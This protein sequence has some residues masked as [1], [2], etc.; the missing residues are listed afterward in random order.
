M[1]YIYS[2]L[3]YMA[4]PFILLKL[5]W[6]GR[7]Q[8]AYRR[9]I[10]E[11]LG[12]PPFQ[13]ERAIWLHAVSVGE[14]AAAIP[15]IK[16]LQARYPHCPVLV[17]TMTPTG[18]DCV[19]KTFGDRV[20]HAYVPYD[21]PSSVRRFMLRVRPCVCIIMETELWPNLLA[22]C[23]KNRVPVCL[24]NARLSQR[25]FQRYR[26]I[27]GLVRAMLQ[28]IDLIAAHHATDAERF[29]QLGAPKE[30]IVVTGNIK[31]DLTLPSDL[32]DRSAA[33]R[34]TLG[35]TRFIWIAASTHEGEDE[36][37]L[38]AHQQ[39]RTRDP[40][41]LL[42]L[43]PR[44]PERFDRIAK[45]SGQMFVTRRRSLQ[46]ACTVDTAVYLADTMGE[47]LLLYCAA[48]VAFVAGSLVPRGGHNVIEAAALGRPIL[49]G[50]HLFNFAEISAE[51]ELAQALIKVKDANGLTE[52]LSRL[53]QKPALR[54]QMGARALQVATAHRGALAKQLSGITQIIDQNER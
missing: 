26:M 12:R 10:A 27:A 44:H 25:S 36:I 4:L 5:I 51:F 16:G 52:A 19:N 17:T 45:L 53:M 14:T 21:L 2:L 33:L 13:L 30:K 40:H 35:K 23:Q 11:R 43:V 54:E 7:R 3:F 20:Y 15:L 41:A 50:P 22:A 42:I 24:A 39:I 46:E 6:R 37:I 49:S 8:P 31:F 18:S 9:R 48:D 29:I 1:R 47:L 34:A 38:A 32:P 28:N